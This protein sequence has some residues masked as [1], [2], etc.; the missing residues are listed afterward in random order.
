[1]TEEVQ[2]S[3]LVTR[4]AMM[5]WPKQV[6]QLL[7]RPDGRASQALRWGLYGLRASLRAALEDAPDA[8]GGDE[9]RGLLGELDSLLEGARAAPGLV[10]PPDEAP[11]REDESPPGSPRLLAL[12]RAVAADPRL[13]AELERSPIREGSDDDIWNDVQRLL[14]RVA[15]GLAGE[16]R[17]RS[18][19][20]AAQAGGRPDEA[21]TAV[22]PLDR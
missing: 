11:G 19:E 3:R 17:R 22:V 9:L 4:S 12:V 21:H 8:P 10:L 14:L 16:W 7:A 5:P 18:L 6:G 20:H 1:M 2:P 13:R 15:P